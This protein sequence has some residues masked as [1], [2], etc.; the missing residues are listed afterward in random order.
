[1]Q[2]TVSP[3][4]DRNEFLR[5]AEMYRGELIAHCY[6]MVGSVH[7]AEDLVQDAYLRAW[8]SWES[9][10]GRSSVRAWLYRIATNVCLTA[11]AGRQRRVL[12]SGLGPAM[13]EFAEP[14]E[15]GPLWLEPFPDR[16]SDS[17]DPAE[18]V[19]SRSNL[20]LALVA[21]LQHLPPRQRAVFILRE[22]LA[23]P[24]AEVA[25]MLEMSVVAA[26]SA[27]QRAR[28]KLD[29]V[30]P[31]DDA[32]IEPD[33]PQARA[34]LQRYMEAF[35]YADIAALTELLRHDATLESVPLRSWQSGKRS[36]VAQLARW[37]L[38]EAGHFRMYPTIA[39]GQPAA[40]AYFRGHLDDEFVAFGVAVLAIDGHH[41]T[42]ITAFLD[43]TLVPAF[44]FPEIAG[45][46][47][48][49]VR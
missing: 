18:I 2:P 37:V 19:A 46:L 15:P 17:S 6:R 4:I 47:T 23:Y 11:V 26:K 25:D 21:S 38:G 49:E 12:P 45:S 1:M 41:V 24:A 29:Q 8:R 42:G 39:N 32:V 31:R 30:T 35:E 48:G 3:E 16:L 34:L 22:V 9:F 7:E 20:R 10:E 14:V 36:C 5:E 28:A 33:S 27:L 13:T 44:G 40:V 43:P